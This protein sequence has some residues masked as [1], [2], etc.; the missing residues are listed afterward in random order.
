MAADKCDYKIKR[1]SH[2][3]KTVEVDLVIYEGE[4]STLDEPDD[5]GGVQPVTRYRRSMKVEERTIV[6]DRP[7]NDNTIHENL[8]NRLKDVP[9]RT[10]I[11]EQN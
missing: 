4:V 8:R 11:A 9:N 5:N 6:F 10:P 1:M 3:D 7:I 2:K